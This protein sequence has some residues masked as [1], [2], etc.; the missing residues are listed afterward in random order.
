[1]RSEED[2]LL[3]YPGAFY[4]KFSFLLDLIIIPNV[5]HTTMAQNFGGVIQPQQTGL[6]A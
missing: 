4:L 2:H 6:A 5:N 1:M 3:F